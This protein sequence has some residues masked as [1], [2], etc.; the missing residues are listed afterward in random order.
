MSW[1]WD[2]SAA[3]KSINILMGYVN[4]RLDHVVVGIICWRRPAIV[5]PA[6]LP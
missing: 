5:M 1:L 3:G 6:L 2:V 4:Y